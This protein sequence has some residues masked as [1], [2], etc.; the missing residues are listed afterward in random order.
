MIPSLGK[1]SSSNS[2]PPSGSSSA[3][4]SSTSS[5]PS[6]SFSPF[7]YRRDVR[8]PMRYR[9]DLRRSGYLAFGKRGRKHRHRLTNV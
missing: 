2:S 3:A 1:P 8:S 6:P 9:R 5:S 7:D 4:T